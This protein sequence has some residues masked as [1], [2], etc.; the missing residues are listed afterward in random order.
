MTSL[1]L[2]RHPCALS[3]ALDL[4]IPLPFS[5]VPLNCKQPGLAP[6]RLGSCRKVFGGVFSLAASA[7]N[8]NLEKAIL[9]NHSILLSSSSFHCQVDRTVK[10]CDGYRVGCLS[11]NTSISTA[12]Q[13]R[14]M[15]GTQSRPGAAAA[16]AALL[17]FTTRLGKLETQRS[18]KTMKN[19]KIRKS[20]L[21][22]W[23]LR[24]ANDRN[25]PNAWKPGCPSVLHLIL[26]CRLSSCVQVFQVQALSGLSPW[27]HFGGLSRWY[28]L[29]GESLK[30]DGLV[31]SELFMNY[32]IYWGMKYDMI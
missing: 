32:C 1:T 12:K 24:Y 17:D 7:S 15:L 30:C 25:N 4:Y 14:S 20:C 18:R 22:P 10:A 2:F 27:L 28:G 6:A 26:A 21:F 8:L 31:H 16:R 5:F 19:G 23:K 13:G 29:L 9:P 3:C 11:R